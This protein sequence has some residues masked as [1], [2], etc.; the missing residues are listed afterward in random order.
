MTPI[1]SYNVIDSLKNFSVEEI[2]K[3]YIE[4]SINAAIAMT[5]TEQDFNLSNVIRTANF[6]GFREVFYV[7]GPRKYDRRG[8]VGVQNYIP[9]THCKTKDEF[10]DII[11]DRYIPI[12]LENNLPL[13][14]VGE[15]IN[16][17]DFT[18]PKNPV[19][20]VGEEQSG[21]PS[22]ILIRCKS[23]IEIYAHGTVRSMNVGTAAGIAM[24]V[25][26]NAYDKRLTI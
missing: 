19:I 6:L 9:I 1:N 11:K 25:Y 8:C 20:I 24:S 16:L 13:N 2:Q 15:P 10:F 22:D 14:C 23:F 17:F 7:G 18:W 26:R 4:N 21:I 3:Y 5:H 12:A